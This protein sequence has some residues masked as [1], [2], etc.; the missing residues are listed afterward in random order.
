[1][2][3]GILCV[4]FNFY[5]LMAILVASIKTILVVKKLSH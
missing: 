4:E 2:Q 3:L 1:M 5:Y